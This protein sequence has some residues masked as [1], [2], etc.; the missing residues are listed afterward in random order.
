MAA[1]G[2]SARYR[3]LVEPGCNCLTLARTFDAF[4]DKGERYRGGG[5]RDLRVTNFVSSGSFASV[6]VFYLIDA[7]EV[8]N[9]A[10]AVLSREPARAVSQDSVSLERR[11]D[12]WHITHI[13]NLTRGG[14]RE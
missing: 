3:S 5:F 14:P 4:Q 13:A 1:T 8:L 2:S 6:S 9:R 11:D 10:G 12:G 7:G